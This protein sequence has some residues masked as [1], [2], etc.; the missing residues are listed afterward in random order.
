M[1]QISLTQSKFALVDDEDYERV[2][3]YKWF[4]HLGYAKRGIYDPKIKNNH[5]QGMHS[6]I[7]QHT[8]YIDHKNRD[9]LDNRK[10]NLRICTQ[11]Q[12]NM[13]TKARKTSKSGIK[14]VTYFSSEDNRRKKPWVALLHKN[15]RKVLYKY[16]ETKEEAAR[17]Y[18]KAA[19]RYYGEFAKLNM[20]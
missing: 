11:S 7:M 5:H 20:I 2:S 8:K 19:K 3:K 15:G 4:Y 17:A 12:N 1:K 6:F 10:E 18:D 14:G 9:G 16:F 13:N